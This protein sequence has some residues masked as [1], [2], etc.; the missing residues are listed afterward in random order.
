MLVIPQQYYTMY[1]LHTN[2]VF[3]KILIDNVTIKKH[4]TTTLRKQKEFT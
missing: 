2:V 4:L 3:I 1:T